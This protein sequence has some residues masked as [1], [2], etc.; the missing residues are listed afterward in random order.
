VWNASVNYTTSTFIVDTNSNEEAPAVP[1]VSGTAVPV[2]STTLYGLTSDQN[3]SSSDGLIWVNLGLE[4]S[5]PS[6][7]IST[8]QG[9]WSYVVSL[10]NTLD[11]TVSNASLASVSTGNFFSASGVFVSG[12]LPLAPDHQVDYVAI[13]RTEDG[14]ETYYLIPPPASGNGNTEYTLPLAQ[15]LSEGFTDT[16]P[17]ANLNTLLQAPVALQN[18]IPPK[19]AINLAFHLSRI[20]VSV[21]NTVYW[22]TGPDTPIGN[23]YNGFAPNNFAEFPSRVSRIIP[24]SAGTLVF[25]VSDIYILAGDGTVGNPITP[26]PYLQRLGLLSYNALTVN[27]SIVYFMTTDKQVVE[28]NVHTGV[29]QIG[30]PIADILSL[31]SPSKSYLTWHNSGYQDQALFTADGSTGWYKMLT[32]ISPEIGTPWCPKANIVDGVGAIQS[33]ETSPGEIQLLLAPPPETTGPI[34]F[35]DYDNYQDNGSNYPA[36]FTFGSVVLAHP[37]QL[38]SIEF[39]TADSH[40]FQGASPLILGVLL[41]EIS[42]NFETLSEF[43]NDPPQLPPSNTLWNQRFYLSQS[44]TPVECRHFQLRVMWPAQNFA[45]QIESISPYGGFSAES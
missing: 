18:S 20:F 42:G 32:A 40:K 41:G 30:Q 37:G 25:T 2:F 29:S 19:G 22:S 21:G 38:A 15:Y 17:D 44:K 27:G 12:G 35:R 6:G 39:I 36:F 14:G 26:E 7:T 11:D 4:G 16:T 9:G 34:L 33:C 45:D 43:T 28:L 8:S 23:G 31:F 24:L 13:F 5:S 1:G 10:V 3:L